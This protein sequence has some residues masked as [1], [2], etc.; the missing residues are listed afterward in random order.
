MGQ[1]SERVS[2]LWGIADLN[3]GA[4]Q[5]GETDTIDTLIVSSGAHIEKVRE[6]AGEGVSV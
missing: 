6:A 1:W 4:H 2:F 3:L 5:D